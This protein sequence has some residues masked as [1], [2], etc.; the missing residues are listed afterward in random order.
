MSVFLTPELRP[1][2]GGTYFPPIGLYG[3]PSFASV[4]KAVVQRW[5]T[6]QADIEKSGEKILEALLMGES[7]DE[8]GSSTKSKEKIFG[9]ALK[10]AFDYFQSAFDKN[11]GGFSSKVSRGCISQ[12]CRSTKI[13]D[14]CQFKLLARVSLGYGSIKE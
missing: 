13:S 12:C 11:D 6:S 9:G 5:T 14:C 8:A 4:L 1:F 7:I 3:Q 10:L 2:L